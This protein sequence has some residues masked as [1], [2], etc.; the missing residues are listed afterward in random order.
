MFHNTLNESLV[1]GGVP[2]ESWPLGLNIGYEQTARVVTSGLFITVY[3]DGRGM[4]EEAISYKTKCDDFQ[5]V[6]QGE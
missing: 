2:L 6:I 3:R 1:A 4:Y 5:Q